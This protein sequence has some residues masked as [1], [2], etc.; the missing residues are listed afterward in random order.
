MYS[1][2]YSVLEMLYMYLAL[3]GRGEGEEEGQEEEGKNDMY[4]VS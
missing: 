1:N 4:D 3:A 2:K